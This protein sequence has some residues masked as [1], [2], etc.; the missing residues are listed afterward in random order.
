MRR[1]LL[2]YCLGSCLAI[3]VGLV[4]CGPSDGG[5]ADG[6]DEGG[7]DQGDRPDA[8]DDEGG[9]DAGTRP[10]ARPRPDA[11]I[12]ATITGKVWAPN[13]G[14]GVAPAGQ[15]IPIFGALVYAS[16]NKPMPIPQEVF[17]EECVEAPGN[18]TFSSHDG[19]FTLNVDPGT[20]WLV[21]QKGQ[22]RLEQQITVEPDQDL[23]L[24]PQDTTLPSRHDAANGAW[25]PRIAVVMGTDDQIEDVLGKIGLGEIDNNGLITSTG[26]EFDIYQ[27]RGA[28]AHLRPSE[29][30]NDLLAS[31]DKMRRYHII[32]FSCSTRDLTRSAAVR[33]NVR[34]Y[35]QE[36]GKIYVT[37]WSGEVMDHAF[38][39]QVTLGDSGADTRGTYSPADPAIETFQG[40]LGYSDGR[41]SP[42][43]STAG[44]TDDDLTAWLDL[45]S[46]P[47]EG[48]GG[49]DTVSRPI[50][51]A[52]IAVTHNFNWISATTPVVVGEENGQPVENEPKVWLSGTVPGAPAGRHPLSVTFEPTGCGRVLYSTYQTSSVTHRSLHPQ[53]RV[54]LYLIMEIGVCTTTVPPVD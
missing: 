14:P 38:P 54:L 40:A 46:A 22:F 49:A 3:S 27:N 19:S 7:N 47:V 53:E 17:C 32:F 48:P 51:P 6:D 24:A 44:T 8:G 21:I 11:A 42:F 16:V 39:P 20:W 1:W 2:T 37:D 29:S 18:S 13:M 41:S 26:S 9:D 30:G 31:L 12:P 4:G 23:A 43:T 5:G 25:V 34:Q 35:V 10:D 50:D 15:E 33:R 45:Q 52:N 28:H 36:G